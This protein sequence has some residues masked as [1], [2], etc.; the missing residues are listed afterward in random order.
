MSEIISDLEAREIS[1]DWHTG[2]W[3]AVYALTSS[4]AIT[5]EIE[6]EVQAEVKELT[7]ESERTKTGRI[8]SAE[9]RHEVERLQSL[10]AY[11]SHHGERGPQD[12]WSGLT[13]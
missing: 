8:R 3:S 7:T 2:Q 13:W 5:G 4:G 11:V 10:L 6:L 1:A 12:G 9:I